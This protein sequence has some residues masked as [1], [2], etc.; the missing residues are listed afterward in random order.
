MNNLTLV[1]KGLIQVF[2][3]E[4]HEALVDARE[5]HEFLDSKQEFANWIKSRIEKYDFVESIDFTTF[6]NF[7]RRD[8]S[9]LGTKRIEYI[10][11]LDMAKEIAMVENNAQGRAI[12]RYFIEVEKKFRQQAIDVSKL[13]PE[14]QLFKQIFDS[15]AKTQLEQQHLKNEVTSMRLEIATANDTI[16][17]VKDTLLVRDE[18]W[19][20]SV[21]RML[22]KVSQN[23]SMSYQE[24]RTE[25]YKTLEDR[26]RCNLS[27]RL[28]NLKDRLS[29][30]GATKTQINNANK[31]DVI[32]N[33]VRL[34]EIYT[35]I[36]KEMSIKYV[37]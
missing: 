31:L 16:Q 29:E 10:L 23:S 18:D 26:A 34:K 37:A 27:I 11:K 35:A 5:L 30:T 3:N 19:R 21:R 33:D 12:R 4:N 13:S 6:D 25:S 8:K 2:K 17:N 36:V 20:N 28:S 14:M 24:V 22:N 7:I 9:N 32:E 15:V 1:E